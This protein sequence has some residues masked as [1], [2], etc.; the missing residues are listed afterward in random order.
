MI[1]MEVPNGW[2][3]P[4][5]HEEHEGYMPNAFALDPL[6]V[7]VNSRWDF[8][9]VLRGLR[10]LRGELRRGFGSAVVLTALSLNLVAV[11]ETRA[12]SFVATNP[13][14]KARTHHQ[15]TLLANGTVL[16]S[17]GSGTSAE[18]YDPA[19]ATWTATSPLKAA[20]GGHTATLL[21]NGKALVAGGERS[22]TVALSS[23]ELYDPPTGTWTLTGSMESARELHT[24]TLL[25]NGRVL[26]VGG[27]GTKRLSGELTS[28]FSLS[29]AELYDPAKGTWMEGGTMAVA[30]DLHTAT[31]L[32]NGKVL[33]AG[34]HDRSGIRYCSA[35]LYDPV[36]GTWTTT[37][38]MAVARSEHTATLLPSGMVLVTGG[39]GNGTTASAELYDPARGSWT[40]TSPMSTDRSRHTANLLPNGMVLVAGGYSDRAIAEPGAELYDPATGTW[41]DTGSMADGRQSYTATLLPSGK[42][43]VAGGLGF[44]G[45]DRGFTPLAVAELYAATGDLV[46]AD[47]DADGV[48]DWRDNCPGTPNP[49]QADSGNDGIGDAC[50]GCPGKSLIGHY[51]FE[52][53]AADQPAEE[54]DS[55]HDFLDG[56]PDGTPYGGPVYRVD[57]AQHRVA[58]CQCEDNTRSLELVDGQSVRVNSP[59]LFHDGY[60]DATLEFMVNPS[61]QEHVAL[62]WTRPDDDD[63]NRFNVAINS[64]GGFGFDYRDPLGELHLTPAHLSLFHVPL[65]SWTHIAVV[66]DTR[67]SAPAHTYDFYVN[68][69]HQATQVDPDP[70]LPTSNEA[71]QISG[72]TRFSFVG[73][74][75]EIRLS[76]RTLAPSEFLTGGLVLTIA[77][78]ADQTLRVSWCGPGSLEQT[79]SLASL[80]WKRA[81]SQLNPQTINA[82]GAMRLFRLRAE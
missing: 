37:G 11:H 32:P 4:R 56:S 49:D 66:R 30:R 50:D 27:F 40:G 42:V 10:A 8:P 12:G 28:T 13:M 51:R 23:A 65:G 46:D 68:G 79:E 33:I 34:G 69:V 19:T 38:P 39:E 31:F 2:I 75:D 35:E 60:G 6:Q 45:F 14:T 63:L 36:A 9:P 76:A 64:D 59:F 1:A 41:T 67:S 25:P 18:L 3:S 21:P 73:L 78:N 5:R 71:W 72:R 16:V 80:D 53:G 7:R 74:V 52:D 82:A 61:Q 58:S 55:I 48:P 15:A 24:A 70:Y 81:P 43:L 22:P 62:F 44:L 57:V 29:S 20:E 26:V 47:A 77:R 17:G 54:A